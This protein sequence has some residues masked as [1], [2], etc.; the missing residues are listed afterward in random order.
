MVT[1][2]LRSEFVGRFLLPCLLVGT[3]VW[4]ASDKFQW[5][6]TAM[7]IWAASMNTI[8]WIVHDIHGE[9]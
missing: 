5:A 6:V 9:Q 4:A 7:L 1:R 8:I 3:S 2:V